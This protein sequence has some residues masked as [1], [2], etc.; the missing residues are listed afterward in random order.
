MTWR[1]PEP[2]GWGAIPERTEAPRFDQAPTLR[3]VVDERVPPG[4]V[5]MI[6]ADG[7]VHTIRNIGAEADARYPD[8][9][10]VG[11]GPGIPCRVLGIDFAPDG[12]GPP[13]VGHRDADGVLHIDSAAT[14]RR[15]SHGEIVA[16][17]S[18]LRPAAGFLVDISAPPNSCARCGTDQRGHD[19]DH[20]YTQPDDALRLAR[21]KERRRA[22]LNPP[23]TVAALPDVLVTFAVDT[24]RLAES[25]RR[26]GEAISGALQPAVA[27][28]R[29]RQA[30]ITTGAAAPA[31]S[32][33]YEAMRRAILA[34]PTSGPIL[35]S[36]ADWD[37]QGSVCAHVCGGSPDHVC[38]ARATT[39][40]RYRLPS[41]GTRAL[42]LCAPC[43]EAETAAA[44][45]AS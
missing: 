44:G 16:H 5:A 34:L 17:F 6:G 39:T 29:A 43:A 11:D 22:R 37:A 40:I 38:D 4:T 21:M 20:A 24:T 8:W 31:E 32:P 26:L 7:A 12:G 33:G 27:A 45:V 41:G 1:E 10:G 15:P 13:V 18:R 36:D 30:A 23:P 9:I 2:G 19:G 28:E 3:L 25:M 14:A 35:A 42:P